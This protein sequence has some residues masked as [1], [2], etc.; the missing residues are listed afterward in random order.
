MLDIAYKNPLHFSLL[1]YILF[2]SINFKK[3]TQENVLTKQIQEIIAIKYTKN[4][5]SIGKSAIE[6]AQ[7]IYVINSY[8]ISFLQP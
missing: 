7:N 8:L 3:S 4:Q 5:Y 6:D 2:D 1:E